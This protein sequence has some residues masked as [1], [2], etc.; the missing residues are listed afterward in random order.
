VFGGISG[1]T[2]IVSSTLYI[3]S[4]SLFALSAVVVVVVVVVPLR[5]F[6]SKVWLFKRVEKNSN[7]GGLSK[8]KN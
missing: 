8:K 3:S 7:F 5:L 4:L 1:K 2:I 6:V